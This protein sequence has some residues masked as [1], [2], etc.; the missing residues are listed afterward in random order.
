MFDALGLERERCLVVGKQP[1][2][3]E[4]L[5][6]PASTIVIN[7]HVH[8]R[9]T[10]VYDRVLAARRPKPHSLRRIYLS[11][12]K[13]AGKR[14]K[15]SN[16]EEIEAL[17]TAHGFSILHP[18]ELP[19]EEQ[20]G[21]MQGAEVIAGT[22]GSALHMVVFAQ[23]GVKVLAFESR[24]SRNQYAIEAA[25]GVD[26]IHVMANAESRPRKTDPVWMAQLDRVRGGLEL[27]H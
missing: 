14:R 9:F 22:D 5:V 19:F 8:P 10:E 21:I 4:K 23:P 11:R 6:V 2:V 18:Q 13:I 20:V 1:M 3:C 25:R 16:E 27:L 24:P 17:L 12:R 7:S 26:A 15:A